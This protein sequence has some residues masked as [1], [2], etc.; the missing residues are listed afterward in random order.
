MGKLGQSERQIA[1]AA[2]IVRMQGSALDRDYIEHWVRL[3]GLDEQWRSAKH[4][5]T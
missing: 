1:D 2:G 4:I 5:G 3:L